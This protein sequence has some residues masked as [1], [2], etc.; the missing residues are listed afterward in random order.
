MSDEEG[1]RSRRSS[2][3]AAGSAGSEHARE[4]AAM[5]DKLDAA[6][7][8]L[9]LAKQKYGDAHQ[10]HRGTST[11]LTSKNKFLKEAKQ[12][13][14]SRNAQV[15]L[16]AADAAVMEIAKLIKE[17]PHVQGILEKLDDQEMTIEQT[18]DHIDLLMQQAAMVLKSNATEKAAYD[19]A[20]DEQAR[21]QQAF[22]ASK[23]NVLEL[24][25]QKKT[26]EEKLELLRREHVELT[27]PV[28][29][30]EDSRGSEDSLTGG[31]SVYSGKRPA[32]DLKP[33]PR[34]RRAT[35]GLSG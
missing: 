1:Q 23:A 20:K 14:L 31:L 2:I 22:D 9:K 7:S 30:D 17:S 15:K 32:T 8:D 10:S 24:E 35:D 26:A 34:K 4:I 28:L 12:A 21:A 13:L 27:D 3:S 16:A 11:N 5:A 33:P 18:H 19:H 29:E 25:G 6:E